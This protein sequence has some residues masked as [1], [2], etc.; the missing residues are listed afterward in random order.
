[1]KREDVEF[2]V[3]GDVPLRGWLFVPEGPGPHPGK[4]PNSRN[5]TRT[6]ALTPPIHR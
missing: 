3:E 5:R 2:V 6:M 4:P 1:V